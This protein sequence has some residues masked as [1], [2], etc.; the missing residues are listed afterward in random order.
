LRTEELRGQHALVSFT[1]IFQPHFLAGDFIVTSIFRNAA[2]GSATRSVSAASGSPAKASHIAWA[3]QPP[4]G[5]ESSAFPFDDV[6]LLIAP[7]W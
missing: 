6:V 7:S 3:A 4:P 2:S 1:E 5:P